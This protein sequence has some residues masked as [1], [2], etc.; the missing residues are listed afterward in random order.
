MKTH[1][2]LYALALC[3]LSPL[4]AQAEGSL[5]APVAGVYAPQA[6]NNIYKVY[7]Q[8]FADS[9][10]KRFPEAW[11]LDHGKRLFFG[12]A[13]G[14]GC[15]AMLDM[16]RATGA[17][18]YFDYVEQWADSLI[19]DKGEIHLYNMSDYN[20]DFINSGKVLFAL[21]KETGKEKYKQAMDVLIRQLSRH[22]R[23]TDGGFW[24]KLVY[25]HQMWLDGIYMAS[26]FMAEYGA[27]F[28]Q[29]QWID[30]AVRQIRVCHKHTFDARTGLYY[31]AWDESKNQRWANSVT[32]QS[33]NFWGRS[34]GWW[35]MA[36]VD[37][38]DF[39]PADH[40]GRA[41]LIAYVQGL[42]ASLPYYQDKDGLWY[43]VID[44]SGDEGN[45][46]ESS[47]STMFIYTLY[48]GVRLGLIDPT[49][50]AVAEKGYQGVLKH[51]IEVDENGVVSLTQT[52]AVAGLGGN[53]YRSGDY[54]YYI[55]EKVRA[56]DPKAVGPFINASLERERLKEKR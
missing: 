21:Y 5:T 3:C 25:Q 51:F 2:Y 16:W 4:T 7:A 6:E 42:A 11:Q 15:C 39:V 19:N 47:V 14:V 30:E 27:T 17:R 55:H 41:D 1:C 18:R 20:L 33:P 36:L 44:R 45:Y 28:N 54:D 50:L 48:K 49:Y 26:P 32:G 35:F 46:L 31:H 9:E 38:L 29:P 12:Y 24:H 22:P 13:Q 8:R 23:T 40:E 37:V 52:C 53:P 10:M 34:I 56:N 43:Q